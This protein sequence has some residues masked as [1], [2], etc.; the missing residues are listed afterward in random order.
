M[1]E[2][3]LLLT[4]LACE[5]IPLTGEL[6]PMTTAAPH[7]VALPGTPFASEDSGRRIMLLLPIREQRPRHGLPQPV[8]GLSKLP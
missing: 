6:L 8:L 4:I 2:V 3:C 7:N 5:G 1:T